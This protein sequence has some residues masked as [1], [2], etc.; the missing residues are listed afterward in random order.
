[1]QCYADMRHR[2]ARAAALALFFIAGAC[3]NPKSPDPAQ[4][5][6][7]KSFEPPSGYAAV[8]GI[9]LHYLTAG[10]GKPVVLLHGYAETSRMWRP[11]MSEL[12][13]NH[14][15]LAPDLRGVGKSDK[16][17]GNYDK[18]SLAAD[19][20][21][22]VKTLGLKQV[23]LVGHDL[24]VM[25]A[26]AYA[27]QYPAEVE[28]VV[29]MDAFLPGIG[30]WKDASPMRDSWH[31]HF[32]GETPLNLVAGRER[33]YLDHLWDNLAADR[34][35]SVGEDDRR[36]YAAEYARPG[37]MRAGFE[38]FKA[39]PTDA[40]DFANFS[41][42]KLTM[43]TMVLAGEKASGKFLIEQAQMVATN[44][45]GVIV[46]GAGHWLMEEAPAKVIP[47]VVTFLNDALASAPAGRW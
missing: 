47:K 12:A 28:K 41:R 8:N 40:R 7:P 10:K 14:L 9:K 19:V 45:D 2:S 17:T 22:L 21:A 30:P 26:Y 3:T 34:T 24:G 39:L 44:V 16:P 38:Y 35:R 29:L 6:G 23:Q 33:L 18:K 13:T 27:A 11:L 20:R 1:M 46:Q 32:H 15:V 43:P 31:F 42:T 4:G 25:V 5:G 37:A 36:F